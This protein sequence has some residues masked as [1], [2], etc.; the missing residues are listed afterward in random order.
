M[1]APELNSIEYTVGKPPNSQPLSISIISVKMSLRLK[2]KEI[3]L[4]VNKSFHVVS[5]ILR[6]K[7]KHLERLGLV[8]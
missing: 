7:T 5:N 1:T 6:S 8:V 4:R 2:Q 3:A